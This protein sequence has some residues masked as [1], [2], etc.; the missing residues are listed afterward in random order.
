MRLTS[1]LMLGLV[2]VAGA[3]PA[4]GLARADELFV[5]PYACKMSG[6]QPV[7]TPSADQKG[8]PVIGGREERTFR[9]CSPVNPEL[10]HR[11][12]LHRFDLD[13]DGKRVPW[14]EVAA[15]AEAARGEGVYLSGDRLEIEMPPQWSLPAGAPCAREGRHYGAF[16][17]FCER[18]LARTE[19]IPV[20]LPA[21]FAPLFGID[22]IFVANASPRVAEAKPIER[23]R[24]APQTEPPKASVKAEP[25]PPPAKAEPKVAEKA[26]KQTP[27]LTVPQPVPAEPPAA[28]AA[29]K[30][31]PAAESAKPAPAADAPLTG[32]IIPTIINAANA[33]SDADATPSESPAQAG[34]AVAAAD[35]VLPEVSKPAASVTADGVETGSIGALTRSES[36]AGL[37]GRPIAIAAFA[38]LSLLTIVLLWRRGRVSSAGALSRDIAAVSF[39]KIHGGLPAVAPKAARDV[40]PARAAQPAHVVAATDAVPRSREDALAVLGMGLGPEANEAAIKKVVDGLRMS[41][42]PDHASDAADRAAREARL[43]QI[44]AAWDILARGGAR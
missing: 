12:T 7:L 35:Q 32:P 1:H 40:A 24:A 34:E 16:S 36:P 23:E 28:S 33:P 20:A 11:W 8:H 42:H 31:S 15:A 27:A 30:A 25:L 21:G 13:C 9:A 17:R 10:C 19:R 44:N 5:M 18:R 41:W 29:S 2:A 14:V 6:G 26:P 22:G 39:D 3:V 38:A 37:D 43:K 4:G